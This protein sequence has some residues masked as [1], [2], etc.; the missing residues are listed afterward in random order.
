MSN[1][2]RKRGG[3]Q[4]VADR[5]F[6]DVGGSD[7]FGLEID[8]CLPEVNTVMTPAFRLRTRIDTTSPAPRFRT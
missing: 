5:Q 1:D 2:E 4:T 8:Q 7:N 3:G 6:V